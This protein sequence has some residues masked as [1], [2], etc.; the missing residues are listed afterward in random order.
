MKILLTLL[1]LTQLSFSSIAQDSVL[2]NSFY[3]D[4]ITSEYDVQYG[5]STT[6]GGVVQELKMDI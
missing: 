5:Q 6:Q 1:I 4:E 2:Y 3:F